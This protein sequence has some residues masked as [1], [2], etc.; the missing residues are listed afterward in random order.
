LRQGWRRLLARDRLIDSTFTNGVSTIGRIPTASAS[1]ADPTLLVV[2]PAWPDDV[3]VYTDEERQ[4]AADYAA[5]T[6]GTLQPLPK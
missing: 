3:R 2:V 5:A 1:R 4:E 6:G